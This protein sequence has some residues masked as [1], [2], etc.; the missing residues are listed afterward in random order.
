[1]LILF[2]VSAVVAILSTVAVIRSTHA[3]HGVLYLVVSFLALSLTFYLLGAP[4]AAAL[5]I[6]VYAGAILVLF[7]FAVF[8]C[9]L[10]NEEVAHE[11]TWLTPGYW[12]GP[13][14]LSL[15]LLIEVLMVLT[16]TRPIEVTEVGPEAVGILLFG[17]YVLAVEIASFLL[18]AGLVGAYHLAKPRES[19]S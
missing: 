5:Q 18:L 12:L 17:P 4:F 15:V 8:M 11:K 1:M 16:Q 13:G 2:Y 6:I 14:L 9:D 10:T 19:V 7:V 3:V